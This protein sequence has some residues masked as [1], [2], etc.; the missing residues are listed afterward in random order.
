MSNEITLRL[1]EHESLET[2]QITPEQAQ[3][4]AQKFGRYLTVQPTW[5]GG[6][7]LRAHQYVGVIALDGLRILIR[8][9][10]PL[11][12]LFYMLTYAY[13]LPQFRQEEADLAVAE[14]LFEFI[15][16]IFVQQVDKLIR[17]GIHRAYV[18]REE[19]DRFL[20]GRLLV[21]EHLR[22]NHIV[23]DQ[24]YQQ[25]NE[26]TEDVLENQ[27]LRHTLWLLSR[28]HYR[29]ETLRHR[30]RRTHSAFA[31]VLPVAVTPGDC[32][33]VHY[34]RLNERYRSRINLAR[35]LLQHLSLEGQEGSQR[36][37][38]FLFDMNQ[39]FELFVAQYLKERL[40]SHPSLSVDIQPTIWL[41][42]HQKERGRPDLILRH[43]RQR[44]LVMDTKY[45]KFSNAPASDDI[46]QMVTYCHTMMLQHSLLI[47][48]DDNPPNYRSE[49]RGIFLDARSLPLDGELS[50][51]RQHSEE[52][53]TH[54][55]E[56][57]VSSLL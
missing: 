5:G 23:Q 21:A 14:D 26:Y 6:C 48:A 1:G 36:F 49:Y 55:I 2:N 44:I 31:T 17:K 15:V 46:Y 57:A 25:R 38:A 54:L 47:Y 12:N 13:E 27:I 41:D 9:K 34:T 24:F 19:N 39:V 4:L 42:T 28:Q 10:V 43:N 16:D 8:P 51:L 56:N 53:A 40:A 52:L 11:D 20:R 33:R 32:D 35:L 45:K 37:F 18:D 29:Q 50:L 22:H 3:L 7:V 30:V